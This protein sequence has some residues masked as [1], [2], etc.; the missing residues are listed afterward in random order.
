MHLRSISIV[1]GL[2]PQAPFMRERSDS[3]SSSLSSPARR[4]PAFLDHDDD[5]TPLALRS[6]VDSKSSSASSLSV[7]TSGVAQPPRQFSTA[8]ASE[9]SIT[10]TASVERPTSSVSTARTATPQPPQS[11]PSAQSGLSSAASSAPHATKDKK[12]GLDK[13]KKTYGAGN[14]TPTATQNSQTQQKS[15]QPTDSVNSTLSNGSSTSAASTSPPATPPDS[16]PNVSES[17]GVYNHTN[18]SLSS[19]TLQSHLDAAV[20]G[21][22]DAAPRRKKLSLFSSKMNASTDNISI[23][24]TMSS[25]SQ[26]LRKIGTFGGKLSKRS[27]LAS[28]GSMFQKDR[29][30]DQ[31]DTQSEFGISTSGSSSRLRK[32]LK[33]SKGSP[34]PASVSHAT[35]EQE[36]PPTH[37]SLTPAA[38]LAREQQER[39]AEQEAKEQEERSKTRESSNSPAPSEDRRLKLIEKEKNKLNKKTRKFWSKGSF[40]GA[41]SV[42]Y[43]SQDASIQSAESRTSVDEL[44]RASSDHSPIS[45]GFTLQTHS[46]PMPDLPRPLFEET[47]SELD[48]RTP[49]QSMELGAQEEAYQQAGSLGAMVAAQLDS[50]DEPSTKPRSVFE[51][52]T[53]SFTKTHHAAP[54]MQSVNESASEYEGSLYAGR[55]AGREPAPP[56]PS[57]AAPRPVRGILKRELSEYTVCISILT[58]HLPQRQDKVETRTRRLHHTL[59][60]AAQTRPPHPLLP[61]LRMCLL[62]LSIIPVINDTRL[63]K[64]AATFSHTR[65]LIPLRL[66]PRPVSLPSEVQVPI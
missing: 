18:A 47:M 9:R 30:R 22:E 35:V 37:G 40:G 3:G 26:V 24:S 55:Q 34:A 39:Y 7:K 13:F 4:S 41:Q 6:R 31:D 8:G 54:S 2:P 45:D 1:E 27:S 21:S 32:G 29:R 59:K 44:G 20:P 28:I 10:P 46:L 19:T 63:C 61:V 52:D 25:A 15:H 11:S 65:P 43:A 5:D 51:D 57:R 64:V 62:P 17:V 36:S 66:R 42:G 14:A 49:R 38:R 33:R 12:T 56:L 60:E 16:S 53:G 50:S 48:D 23:S 58:S